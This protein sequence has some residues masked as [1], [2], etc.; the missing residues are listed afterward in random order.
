LCLI[1]LQTQRD[2]RRPFKDR[3][4]DFLQLVFVFREIMSIP[5]LRQFLDRIG[6]RKSL[7]SR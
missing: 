5:E 6:F 3:L 2:L 4:G 7:R 1:R